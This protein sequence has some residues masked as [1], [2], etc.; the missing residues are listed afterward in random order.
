MK[1]TC[2]NFDYQSESN[3][4]EAVHLNF[5]LST[6]ESKSKDEIINDAR[7]TFSRLEQILDTEFKVNF[8]KEKNYSVSSS[9]ITFGYRYKQRAKK[10][11]CID[12]S[13]LNLECSIDSKNDLIKEIKLNLHFYFKNSQEELLKTYDKIISIPD[14]EISK[15]VQNSI[16]RIEYLRTLNRKKYDFLQLP[17]KLI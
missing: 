10:E 9:N 7:S 6:D 16:K 15:D 13:S 3:A 5:D 14:L 17:H 1:L 8:S 12:S 11:L 4:F 2:L